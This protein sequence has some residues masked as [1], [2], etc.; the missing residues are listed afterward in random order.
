MTASPGISRARIV[1]SGRTR[2]DVTT[3]PPHPLGRGAAVDHALWAQVTS[4]ARCADSGLDPDQWFPV[5]VDPASA[6]REAA[7]A[8]A[9]CTGCLVRGECL[10]L[11]LGHRPARC[12]G[13]AGGGRPGATAPRVAW[14]ARRTPRACRRWSDGAAVSPRGALGAGDGR[15]RSVTAGDRHP[16]PA[17]CARLRIYQR[18]APGGGT[19]CALFSES[20]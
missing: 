9:V 12:V 6:R 8:I 11:S 19:T 14:R 17:A 5:S 20:Q 1:P 2:D 15:G 10:A 16:E 7:A 4:Y 18:Y 13:R 3:P